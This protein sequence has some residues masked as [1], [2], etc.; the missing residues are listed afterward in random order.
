MLASKT[1]ARV[2]LPLIRII[3]A[4]G[5]RVLAHQ[6]HHLGLASGLEGKGADHAVSFDNAQHDDLTS[7]APATFALADSAESAF[8]ALDITLERRTQAFG[9]RNKPGSYDRTAPRSGRWPFR[10]TAA[11][12]PERRRQ[13]VRGGGAWTLRGAGRLPRQSS[14]CSAWRTGRHLKRPSPSFQAQVYAH[15]GHF[16]IVEPAYHR[17]GSLRNYLSFYNMPSGVQG[18]NIRLESPDTYVTYQPL[19]V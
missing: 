17:S 5:E 18:A 7:G 8:V 16:L 15:E 2:R 14:T 3:Q 12:R 10:K 6:L 11:G 1:Q 19:G 13:R 4:S 9:V